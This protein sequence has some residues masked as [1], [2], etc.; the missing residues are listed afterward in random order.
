MKNK[1]L[2]IFMSIVIVV[3]LLVTMLVGC[4]KAGFEDIVKSPDV[5]EY[6]SSVRQL[7]VLDGWQYVESGNGFVLLDKSDENGE[8]I[9]K[10]LYNFES[11]KA[12]LTITE[13]IADYS[14]DYVA[15]Y[16]AVV[17]N[18]VTEHTDVYDANGIVFSA[19]TIVYTSSSDN[20]LYTLY[21]SDGRFVSVDENGKV[22]T[23]NTSLDC[24]SSLV[25]Y[26]ALGDYYIGGDGVNFSLYDKNFKKI[27][28]ICLSDYTYTTEQPISIVMLTDYTMII[29][30]QEILD[31]KAT[32]YEVEV[33]GKKTNLHT[34]AFDMLK[35]KSK[36]IDDL[37][38]VLTSNSIQDARFNYNLFTYIEITPEKSFGTAKIAVFDNDLNIIA[39]ISALM[40]D[41]TGESNITVLQ[42]GTLLL[43]N[44]DTTVV[45]NTNGKIERVFSN[46]KLLAV[47]NNLYALEGTRK[48]YDAKGE[49]VFEMPENS[50]TVTLS[51]PSDFYYYY[52]S[53]GA[54]NDSGQFQE[55]LFYYAFNLK[56]KEAV[57][58]G[59]YSD[60][61]FSERTYT[62]TT[63]NNDG[64]VSKSCYL[65]LDGSLVFDGVASSTSVKEY[66]LTN[67]YEAYLL[68]LTDADGNVSYYSYTIQYDK[69]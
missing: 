32:N 54:F 55:T 36:K 51:T 48:I 67:A 29:Q 2:I 17:K 64:T 57:K 38:F 9:S 7:S 53:E 69:A 56:T 22:K 1:K 63:E 65:L 23:G 39:D 62:V 10:M 61:D 26:E 66:R 33:D 58:L 35:N 47:G 8:V 44:Y 20:G 21:F 5:Y 16:F 13:N 60:I 68:Q 42:D 40:P 52:V 34:Y 24:T 37:S 18:T 14:V 41:A 19:D 4:K 50:T 28:T 3:A 45:V 46:D 11:D 30:T 25:S 31:D 59:E 6:T 12:L 15:T 49:F 43:S 27:S